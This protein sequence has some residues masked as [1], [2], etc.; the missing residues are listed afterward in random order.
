ML[1]TEV[2]LAG[3]SHFEPR[4]ASRMSRGYEVVLKARGYDVL[5]KAVG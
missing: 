2:R 5:P 3:L 1:D 4:H